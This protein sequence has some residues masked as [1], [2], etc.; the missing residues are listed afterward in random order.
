MEG[1]MH[2]RHVVFLLILMLFLLNSQAVLA[3][4]W[5]FNIM[6]I[7][8]FALKNRSIPQMVAGAILSL[9]VHEAGHM[10]AAELR[11]DSASLTFSG[12]GPAVLTDNPDRLFLAAG[13][14]SQTLVGTL[15]ATLPA[16]RRSDITYGFN[17][18][19]EINNSQYLLT[20][21]RSYDDI[22]QLNAMGVNGTAI[23]SG[24]VEISRALLWYDNFSGNDTV[25][26][27]P[28]GAWLKKPLKGSSNQ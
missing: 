18:F 13:F 11:G 21:N 17:A 10:A 25:S 6:G 4:G 15:L 2:K 24:S 20:G 7:D 1:F 26:A 8:P 22:R 16:T 23:A 3:G 12:H 27:R 5:K 9:A 14:I 28:V 19:T